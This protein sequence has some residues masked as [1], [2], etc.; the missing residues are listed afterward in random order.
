MVLRFRRWFVSAVIL[1]SLLLTLAGSFTLLHVGPFAPQVASAAAALDGPQLTPAVQKSTQAVGVLCV[2]S[3]GSQHCDDQDP[4]AQGCTSDAQ[5]LGTADL[6]YGGAVIGRVDRRYSPACGSY[7]VRTFS[8]TRQGNI[9]AEFIGHYTL[10]GAGNSAE[11]YTDMLYAP[12]PQTPPRVRGTV[13]LDMVVHN[14]SQIS[15][16]DLGDAAATIQ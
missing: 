6:Y 13:T 5:T 4:V 8:Y 9:S 15:I 2:Q 11:E 12:M 3:P 10:V 1:I 16:T 14:G 7:W